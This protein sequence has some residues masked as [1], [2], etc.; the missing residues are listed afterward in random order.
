M[1]ASCRQRRVSSSQLRQAL[2]ATLENQQAAIEDACPRLLV[3]IRGFRRPGLLRGK[4]SQPRERVYLVVQRDDAPSSHRRPHPRSQMQKNLLHRPLLRR[5]S[6]WLDHQPQERAFGA[7]PL[8]A[9]Q[10]VRC[11]LSNLVAHSPDRGST[12]L[13]LQR[14]RAVTP[15]PVIRYAHDLGKRR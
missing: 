15:D 9:S 13:D 7:R 11:A 12:H 10:P 6:G 4:A 14:F 5:C 8:K 3:V 2:F 1:E